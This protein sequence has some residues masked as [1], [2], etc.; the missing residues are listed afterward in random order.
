M[1]KTFS[2]LLLL[3]ASLLC[4]AQAINFAPTSWDDARQMAEE[5]GKQIFLYARTNSCRYC[6]QLEKEVFTNPNVIEYYNTHFINYKIDIDDKGPGQ[7]LSKQYGIVGFPTYLYFDKNGNKLHQSSSFKQADALIQDGKNASDSSTALFPML[8]RYEKGETSPELLFNLSNALSYYRVEDNP[9]EQITDQYL[10]TQSIKDLES[11]KN[12]RFIFS[13]YLAFHSAATRY[14][15][16]NQ[17]KFVILFSKAEV[18]KRAQRIITQ[19]ASAAGQANDLVLL[20]ELKQIAITSF[21][22]SNRIVSLA[23]I[24]FY[25]GQRDWSKYAQSTLAYGNSLGA[26]DWQTLYETGAY[27]NYF[28]NDPETVKIGVQ[29]MNKVL[30][31]HKNYEHLCIYSQLQKKAGDKAWALKA[32]REALEVAKS[33][34]ETGSE[35]QALIAELVANN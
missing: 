6:R 23:Q 10:R 9:Q 15:L 35:A 19:T 20:N 27:L 24:Y 13:S 1:R 18:A 5:S 3:L 34:G 29:L 22:N 31:L 32:A 7:A 33:E 16:Q 4:R 17:E 30:K 26:T 11:E 2:L 8:A 12:L 25:S 21:A 28:A 14:L